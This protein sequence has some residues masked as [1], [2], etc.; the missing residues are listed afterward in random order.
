MKEYKFEKDV[1]V[2]MKGDIAHGNILKAGESLTTINEVVIYEDEDQWKSA[3]AQFSVQ[4]HI[5]HAFEPDPVEFKIP[6]APG[7]TGPAAPVE[8][9]QRVVRIDKR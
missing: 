5:V 2:I 7:A 3:K 8:K 4:D 9:K 1:W 6:G